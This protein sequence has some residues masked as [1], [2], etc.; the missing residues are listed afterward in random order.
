VAGG[1]H[2][3]TIL[4]N[5]YSTLTDYTIDAW[6]PIIFN[7]AGLDSLAAAQGD[8][9]YIAIISKEDTDNSAPTGDEYIVVSGI[10][11]LGEEAYLSFTY[12]DPVVPIPKHG[13]YTLPGIY[14]QSIKK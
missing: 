9:L 8:T 14:G 5:A 3:S 12:N 6:N 11:D 2:T 7:A 13:S 4:N 10:N 1:A